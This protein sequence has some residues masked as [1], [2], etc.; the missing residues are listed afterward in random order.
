VTLR[1]VAFTLE[2]SPQPKQRP[3]VVQR[4]DGRGV[5]TFTPKETTDAEKLVRQAAI[6]ARA[7]W[8]SENP[9]RLTLRFF[10]GDARGCDLD[11]LAK[12]VQDA[13][14]GFAYQDDKQIV[15]LSATK[16]ID[17]RHPR[18]EIEIEE[19]PATEQLELGEARPA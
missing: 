13:L 7:R 3:R 18:T 14:N 17:R 19:L 2:G 10:R 1:H 5:M 6:F 15:W 9:I 8:G 16:A 12:L 4:R 11:N